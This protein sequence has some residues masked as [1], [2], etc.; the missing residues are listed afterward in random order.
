MMPNLDRDA[1][2]EQKADAGISREPASLVRRALA[3]GVD[4]AF[5]ALCG[6]L[7]SLSIAAAAKN[8]FGSPGLE[9]WIA[10]HPR[11]FWSLGFALPAWLAL[12]AC[13]AL[14][15]RAGPGKRV[16]RLRIEGPRPQAS[17]SFPRIALRTGIKLAPW[18][19]AAY[20]FLFP[21]PWDPRGSI[22]R[23]RFLLLFGSNLWI[24]IYMASAAMTRRRQ[25]L[26][27][28]ATGTVVLRA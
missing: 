27:D 2:A 23:A 16:L 8:G 25:C 5:A 1:R 24:G 28:L 19:I 14:P 21:T 13:E 26:H 15:G 18:L 6:A 7:A 3:T 9:T 4:L 11:L 17:P 12:S 10:A 20:A 22:E